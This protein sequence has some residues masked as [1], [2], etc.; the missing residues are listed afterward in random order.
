MSQVFV[1]LSI[2]EII[3]GIG[4]VVSDNRLETSIVTKLRI[5][6]ICNKSVE[7]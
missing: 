2:S 4:S 3:F 6:P 5:K 1:Q 7:V